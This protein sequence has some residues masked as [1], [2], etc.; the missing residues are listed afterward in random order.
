MNAPA[1]IAVSLSR[2]KIHR[3]PGKQAAFPSYGHTP[4]LALGIIL[5]SFAGKVGF[6]N[7]LSSLLSGKSDVAEVVSSAQAATSSPDMVLG[8]ATVVT[9]KDN[10]KTIVIAG[11]SGAIVGQ[12]AKIPVPEGQ[13]A[14][15]TTRSEVDNNTGRELLSIVNKY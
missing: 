4:V 12:L 10:G 1:A 15:I 6:L 14:E 2:P 7:I 5:I 3:L 9:P 8:D 13:M 11:Q